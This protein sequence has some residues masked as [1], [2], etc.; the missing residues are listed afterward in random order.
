MKIL[1]LAATEDEIADTLTYLER[2]WEKKSFWEYSKGDVSV[3]TVVSGIGMMYT[4]YALTCHPAIQDIDLIINPGIGAALSRTLDLGKVYIV[5][6]EGFADIGLEESDGTFHDI[7]DLGWHNRSDH[8]FERGIIKPKK[9]INPTFLPR[10]TALTVNK[11]PG[12]YEAI[13]FFEKKFHGD[14]VSLDGAGV[15]FVARMLNKDVISLRVASRY[16]E[17][18]LKQIPHQDGSVK[19]LNMRTID[20]LESLS[21]GEK[22]ESSTRLYR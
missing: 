11:I 7:H 10:A 4:M 1:L 2:D 3:T 13:E 15:F 20:L 12:T 8:P 9:L 19:R 5:E 17:P 16:V 6:H 18:W 22:D 21:A 14:I